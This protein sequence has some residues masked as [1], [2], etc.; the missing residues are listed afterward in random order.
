MA[1]TGN[2]VNGM[3]MTFGGPVLAVMGLLV[4]LLLVDAGVRLQ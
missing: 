1:G 4:A 3:R 2:G